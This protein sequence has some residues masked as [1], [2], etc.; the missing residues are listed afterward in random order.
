MLTFRD[1]CCSYRL[2]VLGGLDLTK[3]VFEGVD[4]HNR[5]P[6]KMVTWQSCRP[7]Q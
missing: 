5:R 3:L 7:R 4:F 6:H 2:S 1:A